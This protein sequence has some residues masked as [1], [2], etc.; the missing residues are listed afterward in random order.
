LFYSEKGRVR[1]ELSPW[2]WAQGVEVLAEFTAKHLNYHDG[3][4]FYGWCLFETGEYQLKETEKV[5]QGGVETSIWCGNKDQ[6]ESTA[7][8]GSGGLK[9]MVRST[10]QQEKKEEGKNGNTQADHGNLPRDSFVSGNGHSCHSRGD[11]VTGHSF[12]T[13][14]D[15]GIRDLAT[16]TDDPI[17]LSDNGWEDRIVV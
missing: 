14:T 11:G 9:P 8:P 17:M 6:K 4:Y 3:W 12:K 5:T 7:E 1:R 15:R 16:P 10:S 13:R 2:D